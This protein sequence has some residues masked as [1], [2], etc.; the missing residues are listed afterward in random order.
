MSSTAANQSAVA[1]PSVRRHQLR[2]RSAV[3]IPLPLGFT[4]AP[5]RPWPPIMGRPASSRCRH[6]GAKLAHHFHQSLA[7][8]G[9]LIGGIFDVDRPPFTQAP[10]ASGLPGF[11]SGIV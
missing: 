2:Q 6:E 11:G 10:I 7:C 1:F 8:S 5:H 3:N 9:S 4:K